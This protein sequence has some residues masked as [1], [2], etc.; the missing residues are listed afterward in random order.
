M[1]AKISKLQKIYEEGVTRENSSAFLNQVKIVLNKLHNVQLVERQ[2]RKYKKVTQWITLLA[3]YLSIVKKNILEKTLKLLI[4]ILVNQHS[5]R[6][7]K[8]QSLL[9]THMKILKHF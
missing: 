8:L 3:T 4:F 7:F 5:I 6:K 9:I 2:K 1:E